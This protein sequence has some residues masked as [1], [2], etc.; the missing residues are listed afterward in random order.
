MSAMEF[1]ES[2]QER[3]ASVTAEFVRAEVLAKVTFAI[4]E[5]NPALRITKAAADNYSLHRNLR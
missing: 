3:D 2:I 1:L 5:K 4:S